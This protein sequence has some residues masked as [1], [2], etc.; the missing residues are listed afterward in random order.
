MSA[1]HA[2]ISLGTNTIRLLVVRRDDNGAVDQIEHLQTGTRLGEGLRDRG[3]LAAG[4]KARTLAA[5]VEFA[6]AARAHDASIACIATS[7][8]RRAS[9]AAAFASELYEAAGVRLQIL[10][11]AVEASASFRGA[12]HNA[13]RDGARIAVLDIGGGS[14]EC[15]VGRDGV[16]EYARSIE[17]GSVRLTERFPALAGAASAADARETARRVR[18]E[19]DVLLAPFAALGK[20]DRVVAVAGTALTIGAIAFASDVTRVSGRTLSRRE[21]DATLDRLLGLPLEARRSL[22]GMLP[23]RADVLVGGG[24]VLSQTMQRF[25]VDEVVLESDDLLLGFLLDRS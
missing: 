7:A 5:V 21:I 16:L 18:A 6:R 17:I 25:A 22:P 8:M 24:L 23:Q 10:D 1:N 3:P 19:L 20:V 11:G 4:A 13:A 15:A 14:T 12:T 2:V 9:D